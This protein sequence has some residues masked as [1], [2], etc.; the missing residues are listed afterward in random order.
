MLQ[1]VLGLLLAAQSPHSGADEARA[2]QPPVLVSQA[3]GPQD[4]ERSPKTEAPP[5]APRPPIYQAPRTGQ[6]RGRMAGITRT[7][8]ESLVRPLALAPEHVAQTLAARPRLYWSIDRAHAGPVIFTLSSRD[9]TEPACELTLPPAARPG[10]HAIDLAACPTD[11]ETGVEYEWFVAVV[12]DPGKRSSDRIAQGWIRRVPA[13][14]DLELARASATEL[15]RRGLWYD[16]LQRADAQ[17][18]RDA[19]QAL[20]TELSIT[21]VELP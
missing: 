2:P 3:S 21:S 13:P 9:A 14:A 7:T 11:L 19:W 18:D 16:A 10:A 1:L 20:L 17:R 5:P 15:A 4:A 8:G 12:A 6:P